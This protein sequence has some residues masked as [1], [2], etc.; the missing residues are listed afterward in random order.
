MDVSA[1]SGSF[2]SAAVPRC[3]TPAPLKMTAAGVVA[4]AL[5]GFAVYGVTLQPSQQAG[6]CRIETPGDGL[7]GNNGDGTLPGFHFRD[8]SAV[9]VGMGFHVRLSPIPFF[10]QFA[11]SRA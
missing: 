6:H 11:D 4:L 2:D 8:V 5:S 3:G 10:T 1:S 7:Q 9:E